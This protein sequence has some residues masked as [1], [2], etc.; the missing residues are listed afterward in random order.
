MFALFHNKFLRLR[1]E[2]QL[3][4][5]LGGF[6]YSLPWSPSTKSSQKSLY[7]RYTHSRNELSTREYRQ[8][9]R[10]QRH[11]Q[12][13]WI[14]TI[15][16]RCRRISSTQRVSSQTTW[17]ENADCRTPFQ[18]EP[19]VGHRKISLMK[20][21]NRVVELGGYDW[22]TESKGMTPPT[23]QGVQSLRVRGMEKDDYSV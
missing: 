22:V 8:S 7:T 12:N 9:Q 23:S 21:Y 18:P 16:Q 6:K 4:N 5:N 2:I 17:I 15:H 14:P 19:V 1:N 11:W 10:W 20:L 3:K 13:T